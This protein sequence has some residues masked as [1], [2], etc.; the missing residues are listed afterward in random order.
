MKQLKGELCVLV[1][2]NVSKF[3]RLDP[4]AVDQ[5]LGKTPFDIL[6]NDGYESDVNALFGYASDVSE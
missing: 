1:I 3:I 4:H 5:F 2:F 6:T